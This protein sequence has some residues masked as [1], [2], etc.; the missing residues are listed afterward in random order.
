MNVCHVH[1][2]ICNLNIVDVDADKSDLTED[3]AELSHCYQPETWHPNIF[4]ITGASSIIGNFI[5]N[6]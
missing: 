3:T 6:S 1:E 4:G 2:L 5:I